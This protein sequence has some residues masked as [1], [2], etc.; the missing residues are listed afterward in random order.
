M[1]K[2]Y[3]SLKSQISELSLVVVPLYVNSTDL[4]INLKTINRMTRNV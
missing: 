4:S 3:L 1:Y 2:A